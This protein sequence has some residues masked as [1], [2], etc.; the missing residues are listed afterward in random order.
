M[1]QHGVLVAAIADVYSTGQTLQSMA[2]AIACPV[3]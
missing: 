1:E 2:M 3:N